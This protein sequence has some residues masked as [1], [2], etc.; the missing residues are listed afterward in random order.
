MS[1]SDCCKILK[2][3][4]VDEIRGWK[5]DIL[6]YLQ[7]LLLCRDAYWSIAGEWKP[8]YGTEKHYIN[9]LPSYL[10]DLFPFPTEEMA[11][12]FWKNFENELNSCKKLL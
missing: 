6:Y 8:E 11:D 4:E 2:H 5:E 7:T 10:R 3:Y 9:H 1:Y 12:N